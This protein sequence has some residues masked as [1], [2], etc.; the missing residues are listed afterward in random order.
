MSKSLTEYIDWLSKR[1]LIWPK[2]P[3]IKPV[4][5]RPHIKPLHDVRTVTWSVYGTILRIAEGELKFLPEREI[6]LQ[7]ALEKTIDEFKM[8]NSMTRKPGAPWVSMLP[9]Y[10]RFLE[11]KQM[12]G[13]ERKGDIPE[14]DASEIW[15]RVLNGLVQ[16]EYQYDQSL[17]GDLD[18]LAEKIS[19]FFHANLQG[20]EPA[21]EA[22]ATLINVS[23]A[24]VR[25]GVLADG[26]WFTLAQMMHA[27]KSQGPTPTL[28]DLFDSQCMTL[29]CEEGIKK[30][31]E[32]LYALA[33]KRFRNMGIRPNEILHVG[34]RLQDDL[35]V[36]KR[37]GMRTALYVGDQ[38]GL[39]AT[40]QEMKDPDLK[41]DRLITDLS[42]IRDIL[43]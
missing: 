8:W 19:Y 43:C 23:Q 36:A 13:T 20:V 26:Q 4:K 10:K 41:P 15:L 29:S 9:K 11:D 6:A 27:L 5:A 40:P 1:D 16:K 28:W 31:S 35:A 21:P 12:V 38:V 14:V 2:P 3:P 7:I 42:Q 33:L 25:Q 39:R 22:L 34:S 30:P 24:G 17:Y 32:T 37:M 18:D